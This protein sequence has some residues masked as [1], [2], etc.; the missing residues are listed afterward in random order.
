MESTQDCCARRVVTGTDAAGRSLVTADAATSARAT[1][2]AFTVFDIWQADNLPVAV[3]ARNT[4]SDTVSMEPPS[5]GVL[6]RLVTFAPDSE[7]ETV[8][9]YEAAMAA[10]GGN[11][12]TGEGDVPGTHVTDTVD[13]VTV[14]DGELHIVLQEGEVLLRPGDSLVQRATKHA[15]SNRTGRPVT[16][17]AT[18]LSAKR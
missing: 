14:L 3:D 1:T 13:V 16:I 6:V 10:V 11:S 2:P 17:V 9:G 4:L 18:L 8:S 15:W 12:T 7:W 5:G